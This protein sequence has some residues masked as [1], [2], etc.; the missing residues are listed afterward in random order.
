M[1]LPWYVSL[2]TKQAAFSASV[3][4][5]LIGGARWTGSEALTFAGVGLLMFSG[6]LGRASVMETL[7]RI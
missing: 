7:V 4:I 2:E 5:L 6:V 3:V 1:S